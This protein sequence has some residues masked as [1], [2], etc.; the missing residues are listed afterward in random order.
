LIEARKTGGV[1]EIKVV[2]R[3]VGFNLSRQGSLA[4]LTWTN[5]GNYAAAPQGLPD[6]D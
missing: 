6:L 1:L 3:T 4:T 2:S 5:Q